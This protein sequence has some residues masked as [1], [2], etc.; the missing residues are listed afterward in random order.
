MRLVNLSGWALAG[1]LGLLILTACSKE[2][3]TPAAGG[4]APPAGKAAPAKTETAKDAAASEAGQEEAKPMAWS[5][6]PTGKRDIFEIPPPRENPCSQSPGTCYDLRQLWVDA[7]IIGSG[8]D[9]AHVILPNGKDLT[10]KVGDELGLNHGRV[11]QIRQQETIV[12]TEAGVERKVRVPQI[13]IEEI[14]V[15]P[16]RPSD[17]HIIE[18][19]LEMKK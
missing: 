3:P 9:V 4:P 10:V 12:K 15:D 7:V 5:Y 16:A 13:V 19:T 17:I 11:K 2:K 6:D 18:K 14:Y 1:I 8:L